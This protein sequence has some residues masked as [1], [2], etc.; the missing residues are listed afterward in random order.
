MYAII[1]A[2]PDFAQSAAWIQEG[3]AAPLLAYT[4]NVRIQQEIED[5]V[6]AP[7]TKSLVRYVAG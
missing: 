4:E 7:A 5:R 1:L 3:P 2:D 6:I